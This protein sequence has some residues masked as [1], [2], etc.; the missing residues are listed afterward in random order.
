MELRFQFV[1]LL[2]CIFC[3]SS[4]DRSVSLP[5]L[6]NLGIA[7]EDENYY[8]GLSSGAINCKD[9]SKKFTKAQLN[10]DFCDCPDGSD[11]PGTSACPSGKFYCKNAGHAPLFIYS[12]R[13]NDGICDCCDGSDE[14]DGKVKCPNTCWE[15]GRVARDKL[16]KKN[17][18][19]SGRYNYKEEGD[20]RS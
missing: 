6:V 12:S 2:S 17:C 7:P 11:E 4:I 1:F 20:R 10:D 16:K 18:N 13:V 19:I 5:S 3:I 9:G 14:H 15:V 8:K